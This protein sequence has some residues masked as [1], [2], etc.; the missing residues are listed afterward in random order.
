MSS[1]FH[2]T[3]DSLVGQ[4]VCQQVTLQVFVQ[5][6][7][8]FLRSIDYRIYLSRTVVYLLDVLKDCL[9]THIVKPTQL[10]QK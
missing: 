3:L 10:D 8:A 4:P 2:Q 1:L 7:H 5:A 6:H 9:A